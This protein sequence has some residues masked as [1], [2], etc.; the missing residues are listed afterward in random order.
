MYSLYC[1]L[2]VHVGASPRAVIR[3]TRAKLRRPLLRC[4]R[5]RRKFIY[6]AV[7]REHRDARALY[8]LAT[9]AIP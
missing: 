6:R 9:G 1:R 2:G 5:D 8:G 3:A 4:G 7:L